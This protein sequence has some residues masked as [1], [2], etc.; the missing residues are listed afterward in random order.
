MRNN[1]ERLAWVTLLG[2]FFI[3]VTLSVTTPLTGRWY[4]RNSRMTQQVSL[5]I[6]RGPLSVVRGGRGRPVSVAEDSDNVLEG[7]RIEAPNATSGRLVIEAPQSKD[8]SPLANVQL[9]DETEIVLASARSPRFSSSPLPHEIVLE[10]EAGRMRINVLGDSDR[11]T[12]AEVHTAHGVI[13]LQEGSYEVKINSETEV[14]VRYGQA[15]VATRVEDAL[16]LGPGERALLGAEDVDGPLPAARNLVV[17]GDFEKPLDSEWSIHAEQADPKQAPGSVDVVTASLG[18][19]ERPVANFY[20]NAVN[21]AEV[22][23]RQDINYDVRDFTSLELHMAVRIDSENILGLGG[24]GWVGSECPIMVRL[25]YK[26]IHGTDREWLRGFYIGEPADGWPILGW[27]ERLEPRTWQPY[28]SGNMM[29]ELTDT[30][31]ALIKGISI[32]ASGHSFD[33]MVT[34]VELLAQ[35]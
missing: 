5:Q 21:H 25:E 1:P 32:Y 28:N 3:C 6:Q 16:S 29:E 34:E 14:T 26:D 12:I 20:R 15:D 9:Y 19:E 13:T 8:A 18:N 33:A 24:C 31:P 2:S 35:E 22:G 17:N 27:H 7:S 30:P 23:I 10:M 11:S 4:V